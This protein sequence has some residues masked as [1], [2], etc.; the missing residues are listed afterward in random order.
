MAPPRGETTPARRALLLPRLPP[1]RE[2]RREQAEVAGG[3]GAVRPGRGPARGEGAPPGRPLG[4][5]PDAAARLPERLP[6]REDEGRRRVG[7]RPRAPREGAQVAREAVERRQLFAFLDPATVSRIEGG[8]NAQLRDMSGDRR[9]MRRDAARR[10]RLPVVL[11]ARGI[12]Q[13]APRRRSGRCRRTTTST[14]SARSTAATRPEHGPGGMGRRADVVGV[15]SQRGLSALG[16][17]IPRT[18]RLSANPRSPMSKRL[19]GPSA[20]LAPVI[21]Q[22]ASGIGL[23]GRRLPGAIPHRGARRPWPESRRRRRPASGPPPPPLISR[24]ARPLGGAPLPGFRGDARRRPPGG[25]GPRAAAGGLPEGKIFR[26]KPL[27]GRRA[28]V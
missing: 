18:R 14:C 15:P 11:H 1:G 3:K 13:G 16:W 12:A 4:R 8:V 22:I 6:E 5:A 20:G 17:I 23:P 25:G 24:C 7:A 19:A 10:G 27:D 26:R 2:A 21:A 9:G 28:A